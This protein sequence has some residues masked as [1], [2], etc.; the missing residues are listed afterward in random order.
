MNE[1]SLRGDGAD[2]QIRDRAGKGRLAVVGVHR[3]AAVVA[4]AELFFGLALEQSAR[5]AGGDY[6][7]V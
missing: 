5:L 2:L 6:F 3:D 4:E 1:P 7:A